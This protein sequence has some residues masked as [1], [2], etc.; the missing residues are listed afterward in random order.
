MTEPPV[1][2]RLFEAIADALRNAIRE[3]TYPVSEHLPSIQ[4][5]SETH[6][7]SHMTIKN[8][9]HVL[10][11]EG[12][13]AIRAGVPAQVI[14]LPGTAKPMQAQLDELRT[15]VDRLTE[16]LEVLESHDS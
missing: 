16:R 4:Q 6:G 12:V 13:L 14:A 11:A 8:A 15:A 3:G 7:A 5:L 1:R 10:E 9:L 2:Q